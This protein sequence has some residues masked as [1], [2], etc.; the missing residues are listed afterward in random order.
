MILLLLIVL[1]D[2]TSALLEKIEEA[3]VYEIAYRYF[4][5]SLLT[6]EFASVFSPCW[7]CLGLHGLNFSFMAS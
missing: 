2:S 7:K 1:I 5:L 6:F 3:F 4:S